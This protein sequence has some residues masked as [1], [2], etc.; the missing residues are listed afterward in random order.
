V[1]TLAN[2]WSAD[3]T[4]AVA[5]GT[6]SLNGASTGQPSYGTEMSIGLVMN[7]VHAKLGLNTL[8]TN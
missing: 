7:L 4:L 5:V 3:G 6:H 1:N 2:Y 8:C